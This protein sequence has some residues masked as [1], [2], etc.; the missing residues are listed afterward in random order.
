MNG[1]YSSGAVK[2]QIPTAVRVKDLQRAESGNH[3]KDPACDSKR[4]LA[5]QVVERGGAEEVGLDLGI[6]RLGDKGGVGGGG[7]VR[8]GEGDRNN[9]SQ[10]RLLC[11]TS[12]SPPLPRPLRP[13]LDLP[14]D[15]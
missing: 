12:P 3:A 7:G 9:E 8:C 5:P 13:H 2:I 10:P 11:S 4:L 1:S 14:G 15:L 6:H